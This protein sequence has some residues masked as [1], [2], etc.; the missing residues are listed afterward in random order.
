MKCPRRA[1][2]RPARARSS[3]PWSAASR[4]R[5]PIRVHRLVVAPLQIGQFSGGAVRVRSVVG[6]VVLGLD[7]HCA[8]SSLRARFG[9]LRGDRHRRSVEAWT[10]RRSTSPRCIALLTTAGPASRSSTRTSR[11]TPTLLHDDSAP[12]RTVLVAEHQ[13]SG[14][15]RLDRTWTSPPRAGLT[16]SVAVRPRR[17]DPD[18]GLAAAA[19]RRR[20]ARGAGR[21]HRLRPRAEV[22]QRRAARARPKARWPASSPRPAARR[23]SSASG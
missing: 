16:F 6:A 8:N 3:C 22:A 4:R 1:A 5:G 15:G 2:P 13:R 20:R 21:D 9:G 23:S 10:A 14:R 12:D 19:H 17:P 18:V 11:R 7:G